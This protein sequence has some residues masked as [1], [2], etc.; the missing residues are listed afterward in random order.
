M[1]GLPLYSTARIRLRTR[2][3]PHTA[4]AFPMGWG[5]LMGADKRLSRLRRP[6][7]GRSSDATAGALPRAL[8][9]GNQTRSRWHGY[10]R[11]SGDRVAVVLAD[12]GRPL[13]DVRGHA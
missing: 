3:C 11:D 10:E 12:R 7:I 5:W 6:K 2:R 1:T 8:I 4:M 9:V 13:R